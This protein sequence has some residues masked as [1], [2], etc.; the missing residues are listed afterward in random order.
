LDG[1][2]AN[3]RP[4]SNPIVRGLLLLALVLPA[5]PVGRVAYEQRTVFAVAVPPAR[6]EDPLR[7]LAWREVDTRATTSG[8]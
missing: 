8:P 1:K 6:S 5:A 2:A 7:V 4:S 3:G